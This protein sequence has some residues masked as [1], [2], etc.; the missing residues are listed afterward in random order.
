MREESALVLYE[1][2]NTGFVITACLSIAKRIAISASIKKTPHH[3]IKREAA[4]PLAIAWKTSI[5]KECRAV[6]NVQGFIVVDAFSGLRLQLCGKL[7][8]ERAN[9]TCVLMFRVMIADPN[10]VSFCE[11]QVSGNKN[12]SVRQNVERT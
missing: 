1:P 11:F 2:G 4:N 9:T 8:P 6:W 10:L 3:L 7:V 5:Q 12:S